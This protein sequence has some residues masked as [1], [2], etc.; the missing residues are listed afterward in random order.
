LRWN[1]RPNEHRRAAHDLG[2]AMDW[3][4]C[5]RHGTLEGCILNNIRPFAG[6]LTKRGSAAPAA[7]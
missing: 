3:K 4:L 1:T 2:V 6:C 7:D 5:C